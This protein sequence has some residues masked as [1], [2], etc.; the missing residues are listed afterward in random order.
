M[1]ELL[2]VGTVV[3][4]TDPTADLPDGRTYRALVRGYDLGRTKYHLGA[5]YAPGRFCDGGWWAF[6]SWVQAGGRRG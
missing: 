1:A 2:P 4:V 5:E 3:T 6:P